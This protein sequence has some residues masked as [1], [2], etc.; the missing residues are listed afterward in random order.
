MEYYGIQIT[1]AYCW[2][3]ADAVVILLT[4]SKEKDAVK[5]TIKFNK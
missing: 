4:F 5:M 2:G 3:H 1:H